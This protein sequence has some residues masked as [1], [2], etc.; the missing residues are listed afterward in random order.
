MRE[1]V[2]SFQPYAIGEGWGLGRGGWRCGQYKVEGAGDE[3]SADCIE[4]YGLKLLLHCP[5]D[6]EGAR[7][8]CERRR[9]PN[10]SN[11]LCTTFTFGGSCT[12]MIGMGDCMV[13]R[14]KEE[15]QC[16]AAE[17]RGL[18]RSMPTTKLRCD[19]TCTSQCSKQRAGS[20]GVLTN[21]R[22]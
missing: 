1:R 14:E 17:M 15:P 2:S 3:E 6:R 11:L 18:R 12:R 10:V 7:C 21:T 8:V 13:P 16:R 4:T 22:I 19:A 9:G 5:K 20:T